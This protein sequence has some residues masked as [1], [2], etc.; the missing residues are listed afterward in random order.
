[1]SAQTR[2]PGPHKQYLK[3]RYIFISYV[4]N[5]HLDA[6]IKGVVVAGAE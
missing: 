1:M 3:D 2:W 6:K 4:S 5:A